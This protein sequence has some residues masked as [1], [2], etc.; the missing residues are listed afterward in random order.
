M[1]TVSVETLI[2]TVSENYD[3]YIEEGFDVPEV[4]IEHGNGFVQKL[5]RE[6][7]FFQSRFFYL[8]NHQFFLYSIKRIKETIKMFTFNVQYR[9]QKGNVRDMTVSLQGDNS[10]QAKFKLE[11]RFKE[12][13]PLCEL[14]HVGG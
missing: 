2:K 4:K 9:D 11:R 6:S 8:Q 7:G 5:L 10:D 12:T 13:F 1:K 3:K 14:I